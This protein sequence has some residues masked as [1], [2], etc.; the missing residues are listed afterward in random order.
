MGTRWFGFGWLVTMA[1]AASLAA[2]GKVGDWPQWRGPN[3]DGV[4]AAFTEPKAWPEKLTQKWKVTVGLG[5]ATPILVGNRIYMFAREDGNETMKAL[6]AESGNV[7]W[8]TGYPAAFKMNPAAARHGEG[9][10]STPTFSSGKLYTLGMTGIV[11]AFDAASGK[12]LWQTA[13]TPV[14]PMYHTAQS[15]LVDRGLVI[16]HVGG[17]N[18]GALTAYEA[19][20]GAVKWTWNGDGPSYG[21]A[22]ALDV[23]GTRHVVVFSQENL[24][25]VNAATGELLWRRPFSTSATQNTITPVVYGQT[26]IIS[27]IDKPVTAFRIVRRDGKWTP[28]D[29]WEN[30]EVSM[31]MSNGVLVRDS[32]CGM[33]ARNRGQF[34]CL[35][36]KTGKTEWLSEPRQA[37]NAAVLRAGDV[38][39]ALKDDAELLVMRAGAKGF[40]PVR[41]YTVADSAT[42]AQPTISGNRIFVKD[43]STLTLW[44]IQ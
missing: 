43:V 44:V 29:V 11:S 20:T 2:Q 1:L 35:N 18:Q 5:Y 19:N 14:Q 32:L 37:T 27:G 38:W 17:H 7:V 22:V 41:R 9:P 13:A 31:Y 12:K 39:F 28:E 33:S 34:F 8:Q 23:E 25:G 6:D 26:L 36:A 30:S 42:W 40:D 21:S 10:K 16:V 15:P 3:R 4:I 24:V